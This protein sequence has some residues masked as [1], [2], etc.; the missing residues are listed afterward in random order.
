MNYNVEYENYK[1]PFESLFLKKKEN[2]D[3]IKIGL[4]LKNIQ[5][6]GDGYS[7]SLN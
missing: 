3:R 5:N 2:L 4:I 6:Y 1:K 7:V